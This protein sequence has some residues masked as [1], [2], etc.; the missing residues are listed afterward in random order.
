M[1][2]KREI[3]LK[4]HLDCTNVIYLRVV[5]STAHLIHTQQDS[6]LDQLTCAMQLLTLLAQFSQLVA[7]DL[8]LLSRKV[9]GVESVTK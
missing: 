1:I 6:S 4:L 9:G 2:Q 5:S 7:H 8:V 3:R